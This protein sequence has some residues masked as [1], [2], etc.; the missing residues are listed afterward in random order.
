MLI[1]FYLNASSFSLAAWSYTRFFAKYLL[2]CLVALA[3]LALPS[4]ARGDEFCRGRM[5][6]CGATQPFP[7][8]VFSELRGPSGWRQLGHRLQTSRA[9]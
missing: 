1:A 6:A 2:I 8:G 7:K 4:T 5:S 9:G 3:P